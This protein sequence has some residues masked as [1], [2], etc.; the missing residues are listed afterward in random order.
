[1]R[2][3]FHEHGRAMFGYAVRLTRDRSTAEDIVQE[4][5]IRAWK[6]PD[7]L[8]NGKGSVRGWLLTVVRNLVTDDIRARRVR[9]SAM[10]RTAGDIG[11]VRDPADRIVDGIVVDDAL[12][13]LSTEHRQALEQIYLRGCTVG[14]AATV[15]GVPPGTVK[16][17]SFYALRALREIFPPG[18]VVAAG[19]GPVP[20]P[21]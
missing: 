10:A 11:V 16:S 1:M 13:R 14:E 9:M 18:P 19:S 21:G 12:Q 8:V 5:L 15:L 6:N 4:A 7:C 17:R 20:G 3:V 2:S